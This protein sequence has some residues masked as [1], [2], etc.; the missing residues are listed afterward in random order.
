MSIGAI[1]GSSTALLQHLQ[2]QAAPRAS[3][4]QNGATAAHQARALDADHDG[5]TDM[6]GVDNNDPKAPGQHINVQA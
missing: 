2:N 6:G 3:T 1:S 5:D 4:L